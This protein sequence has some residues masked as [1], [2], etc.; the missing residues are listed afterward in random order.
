M[1]V[2]LL[3]PGEMGA[4]V[5]EDLLTAGHH[6]VWASAGRS[7]ETRERAELAGLEDVGTVEGSVPDS[8]FVTAPYEQAKR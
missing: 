6:V 8:A 1:A 4:A 2:G 5:G 7:A 3:H